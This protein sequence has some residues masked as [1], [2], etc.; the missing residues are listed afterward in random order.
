MIQARVSLSSR[1]RARDGPEL[2]RALGGELA[3]DPFER[4]ALAADGSIELSVAKL[5]E[6][7]RELRAR[8]E[9]VA[10]QVVAGDQRRRIDRARRLRLQ[11]VAAVVDVFARSE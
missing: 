1:N 5:F 4:L 8:L 6:Q 10:D 2:R 9:A 7:G 11:V 3:I